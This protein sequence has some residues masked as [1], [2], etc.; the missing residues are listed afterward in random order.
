MYL[1]LLRKNVNT[2]L[3]IWEKFRIFVYRKR[4]MIDMLRQ[5]HRIKVSGKH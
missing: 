3:H 1:H 4:E 2:L 5:G